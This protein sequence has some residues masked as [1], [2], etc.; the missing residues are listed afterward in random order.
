M[1]AKARSQLARGGR[2]SSYFVET[3][4]R[5]TPAMPPSRSLLHPA[6]QTTCDSRDSVLD[7]FFV[8][9][10]PNPATGKVESSHEYAARQ[11]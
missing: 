8:T 9:L 1:A 6:A 10:W 3:F 2:F 5:T 7:R 11:F 4:D